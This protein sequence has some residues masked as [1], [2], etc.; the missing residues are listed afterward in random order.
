LSFASHCGLLLI[1][2]YY[3]S[4]LVSTYIYW[5]VLEKLFLAS[6]VLSAPVLDWG[7]GFL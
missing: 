4:G 2:I 3:Y 6:A 5:I 7:T 1:L